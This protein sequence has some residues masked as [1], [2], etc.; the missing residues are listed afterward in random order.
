MEPTQNTPAVLTIV[1]IH[2][3]HS[4]PSARLTHNVHM[5][6]VL[7][8]GQKNLDP[9]FFLFQKGSELP[10]PRGEKSAHRV[11]GFP[12]CRV[13]SYPWTLLSARSRET[14]YQH[15]LWSP[16]PLSLR[17]DDECWPMS[18]RTI[19]VT[20]NVIKDRPPQLSFARPRVRF[21]YLKAWFS[22]VWNEW[23]FAGA[24]N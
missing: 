14:D 16:R 17:L 21:N 24:I 1:R 18:R 9:P 2:P 10:N 3:R 19:D 6:E 23:R 20:H 5:A 12:A 13:C 15:F 8:T 7:S 22:S 4:P 11:G